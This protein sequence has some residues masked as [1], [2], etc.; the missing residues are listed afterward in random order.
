MEK[1]NWIK[2]IALEIGDKF[3]S[4]DGIITVKTIENKNNGDNQVEINGRIRIR[5]NQSVS[6]I[7]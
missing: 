3:E 4:R 6:K 2:A 1:V 5:K 7:V